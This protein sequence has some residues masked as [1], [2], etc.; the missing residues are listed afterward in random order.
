MVSQEV[1]RIRRRPRLLDYPG[2]LEVDGQIHEQSPGRQLGESGAVA[3]VPCLGVGRI[4][5][6]KTKG[7]GGAPHLEFVPAAYVIHV[8]C[9][10]DE[11]AVDACRGGAPMVPFEVHGDRLPA[12]QAVI[13]VDHKLD[14]RLSERGG[15]N[16]LR[17]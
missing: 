1:V 11:G 5:N 17:G 7:R 12:G 8:K 15:P 9:G 6:L 10:H 16:S 2:T 4:L 3:E 13:G 14:F